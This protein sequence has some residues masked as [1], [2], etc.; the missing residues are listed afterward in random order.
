MC[1]PGHK[2]HDEDGRIKDVSKEG[3]TGSDIENEANAVAGQIMRW[4]AKAN[5]DSFKLAGLVEEEEKQVPL[6]FD[7]HLGKTFRITEPEGNPNKPGFSIVTPENPNVFSGPNAWKDR[8]EHE[9]INYVDI[10]RKNFNE[11]GWLG[12]KYGQITR[13]AKQLDL[14]EFK[15]KILTLYSSLMNNQSSHQT[16]FTNSSRITFERL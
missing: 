10:A 14:K 15:T 6:D 8:H 3:S 11:P 12:H 9:G 1:S 5:P 2:G 4:Y 13:S 7:K 16:S